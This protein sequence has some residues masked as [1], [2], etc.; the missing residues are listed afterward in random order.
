AAVTRASH[1]GLARENRFTEKILPHR[2][3][4][5][6]T[7][8]FGQRHAFQIHRLAVRKQPA[9]LALL[10][11]AEAL[12]DTRTI[13]V[14]RLQQGRRRSGKLCGAL[15][16]SWSTRVRH[17]G[18]MAQEL[19]R[20]AEVEADSLPGLR[21]ASKVKGDGRSL[22][23]CCQWAVNVRGGSDRVQGPIVGKRQRP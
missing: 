23:R 20:G 15:E 8:E 3:E 6:R 1:N 21:P 16:A 19:T 13:A 10:I 9:D 7:G 12:Q 22:Y 18:P 5:S 4:P 11:N 17:K 2:L 14:L